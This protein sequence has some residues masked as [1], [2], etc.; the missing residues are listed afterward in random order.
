MEFHRLSKDFYAQFSKYKEVLTKEDRPYYVL[1][2]ELDGLIYAIPLRSHIMHPYCF[3][4]DDSD[5]QNR[6]LDYSKAVLITD[7]TRYID[8]ASVTIRQYEYN[9]YKQREHLIRKQFSSY[10]AS[11]KKEVCRH[12]KN[13]NIPISVLFEPNRTGRKKA[14]ETVIQLVSRFM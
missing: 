12:I 8:P 2:L 13:P 6:G 4:A 3:I 14:R 1:L 9:V 7:T 11:Y 10:V 5:G